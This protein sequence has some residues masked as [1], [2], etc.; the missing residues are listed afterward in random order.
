MEKGK[1]STKSS[2]IVEVIFKTNSQEITRQAINRQAAQQQLTELVE[3]VKNYGTILYLFEPIPSYMS[4]LA[5]QHGLKV[6][7]GEVGSDGSNLFAPAPTRLRVKISLPGISGLHIGDLFW[8]DRIQP[9]FYLDGVFTTIGL[10]ES[11]TPD[12]GW[13]TSIEGI[14]LFLGRFHFAPYFLG[15][16]PKVNRITQ[17]VNFN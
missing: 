3:R 8:V 9:N 15:K 11:I 2:P 13:I 17:P 7:K 10:A 16:Q 4:R 6:A 5:Y 1:L 14:F 12:G